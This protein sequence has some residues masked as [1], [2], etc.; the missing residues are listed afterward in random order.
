[1]IRSKPRTQ[2]RVT[3]CKDVSSSRKRSLERCSQPRAEFALTLSS[4]T[5][6][7]FAIQGLL[8]KTIAYGD[9]LRCLAAR[10]TND[11]IIVGTQQGSMVLC[12]SGT[13]EA[14]SGSQG[15]FLP[16]NDEYDLMDELEA[17]L[18]QEA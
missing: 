1:V 9:E 7:S 6:F 4:K 15:D 10:R 3:G 12:R 16:A 18:T 13:R 8:L 2:N 11:E 5:P 14:M 17:R